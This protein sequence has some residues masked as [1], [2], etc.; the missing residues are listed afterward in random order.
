MCTDMSFSTAIQKLRRT[1]RKR[2]SLFSYLLCLLMFHVFVVV[3]FLWVFLFLCARFFSFFVS[4]LFRRVPHVFLL[5][6]YVCPFSFPCCSCFPMLFT[7]KN[8]LFP[9]WQLILFIVFHCSLLFFLVPMFSFLGCFASFS[10]LHFSSL[11]RHLLCFH[12][13]SWTL[14]MPRTELHHQVLPCNSSA[15]WFGPSRLRIRRRSALGPAEGLECRKCNHW[16][17]L[18]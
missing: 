14:V 5:C 10:F 13:L 11:V 2:M 15:V 4:P 1:S 7:L 6:F 9:P 12:F 17:R 18:G 3:H 8:P 16:S